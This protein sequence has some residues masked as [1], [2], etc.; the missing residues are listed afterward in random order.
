MWM[1]GWGWSSG[2]VPGQAEAGGKFGR[3]QTSSYL[4]HAL[5]LQNL[6]VSGKY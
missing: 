6:G 4:P 5:C 3:E 2:Q 1:V